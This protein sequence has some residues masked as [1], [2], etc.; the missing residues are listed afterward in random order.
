MN[1]DVFQR[2]RE[3]FHVAC[4]LPPG[5]RAA[6]LDSACADPGLRREVEALL[7]ADSGQQ[8]LLTPAALPLGERLIRRSLATLAPEAPPERIGGYRLVERLGAGGMGEVFAAEQ[9]RPRRRVALKLMRPGLVSAAAQRRFTLEAEVLGRLEHENIARIFEAGVDRSGGHERPYLVME[10]VSGLP[11]TRHADTARLDRRARVALL[12]SV[13]D[14]VQHAHQRGVIHRDLKPANILVT[15][16]GTPKILDFG[17]A[18]TVDEPANLTLEHGPEAIIGTLAYMSPEQ[19]L[20]RRDEIDTRCDVYSLGVILFEL[21]TG[22]LP[23]DLAG[24]SIAQA[25]RLITEGPLPRIGT[26]HRALRGDLETIVLKA[27]Q[28][29]RARRYGSPAELAAD[30]RRHLSGEPILARADSAWYVLSRQLARHRLAASLG[31]GGLVVLAGSV[32]ALAISYGRQATLLTQAHEARN[33]EAA[34]RVAAETQAGKA[35]A[36]SSF[37][38][39]M[40]TAA[41]AEA[42]DKPDV[43]VREILDDAAG[44]IEGGSLA[45]QP[46]VEAAVRLMLGTAYRSLGLVAPAEQHLSRAL[47]QSA[48]LHGEESYEYATAANELAGLY[49]TLSRLDEAEAL[50]R[51]ALELI[52]SLRGERSPQYVMA[53]DGVA[54]TLRQRARYDEA[55]ALYR[56]ALAASDEPARADTR[57]RAFTLVSL[58]SCLNATRDFDGAEVAY[59]EALDIFVRTKGRQCADAAVVIGRLGIVS[60]NRGDKEEAASLMREAVDLLRAVLPADHPRLAETRQNLAIAL[61]ESDPAEAEALYRAALE[62]Y[63]EKFGPESRQV[64]DTLQNL[65]VLLRKRGN[66][67]EALRL[68]T[69]ALR[70]HR[71]LLEPNHPRLAITL[72]SLGNLHMT[73]DDYAAAEPLVREAFEIRQARLP[74]SHP[75]RMYATCILGQILLRLGRAAEAEP[76]AQDCLR[77]RTTYLRPD[78]PTLPTAQAQLGSTL[79]ALGRLDEAEPLLLQA[80]AAIRS[81]PRA[82]TRSRQIIIDELTRLYEALGQPEEAAC[83]RETS[84]E[85]QPAE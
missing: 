84:A 9:E 38:E 72:M 62:T 49:V 24:Q 48:A 54:E 67:D 15:A 75:D 31:A 20:G 36:I 32:V 57:E 61:Q 5:E 1:S 10:F 17:I 21:L 6:Y 27:L 45:G 2:V 23:Y 22:R 55:I 64:A 79:L 74:E 58:G 82:P 28:R 12:A 40:L 51:R 80:Y 66:L 44:E 77:C 60:M 13:C 37:V 18:R 33:A 70:L 76:L 3:L 19:V 78:D 71:L 8:G 47:E 35:A 26:E 68:Y 59:R 52:R 65:A 69:E 85:V 81:D 73:R 11:L 41:D 53:L 63:R 42:T 83:W 16:E 34:A 56:Q 39:R 30:L 7:G 14:G 50:R 4:E 46:D 25:A 29:D 43:T